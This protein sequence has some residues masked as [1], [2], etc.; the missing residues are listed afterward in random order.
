MSALLKRCLKF[1]HMGL[2]LVESKKYFRK[3]EERIPSCFNCVK[4]S[5]QT[6]RDYEFNDDVVAIICSRGL[7][8]LIEG[9]SFPSC[10]LLQLESVGHDD[11]DLSIFARKNICVCNARSI[12][13]DCLAEF[14]IFAML[15]YAKRFHKSPKNWMSRP[16]RNYHYMTELAGKTVGIMGVGQIGGAIARRLS[17]FGMRIYGYA[18]NTKNK[19]YFDEI[20]HKHDLNL[21]L[22]SCDFLVNVLPHDQSTIGL[23][24]SN[25]LRYLK[26]S[27]VFI[28]IGRDSVYV[29][30]D[31]EVFMREHRDAVAF[32]DLFEPVPRYITN[33]LRRLSN[34]L[35]FPRISAISTESDESIVSL[36]VDN[37]RRLSIDTSFINRIS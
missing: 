33:P 17:M 34:V 8:K 35:I 25:S 18:K 22:S 7:A 3:I 24:D 37:V 9:L 15:L 30:K 10:R 6:I 12:Y 23:L 31:F 26:P 5:K 36:I 21:F 20:Y 4:V 28:N 14:V 11:L 1:I 19:D 2:V 29:K 32:L 27:I 16:L 13:D